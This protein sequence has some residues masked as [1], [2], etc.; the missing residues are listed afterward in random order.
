[1]NYHILKTNK[2]Q[3]QLVM[4]I[5]VPA[6]NNLAAKTFSECILEDNELNKVSVLSDIT[7]P[8]STALAAGTLIEVT[9]NV[10]I[11]PDLSNAAKQA[12]LDA[13]YT[14]AVTRTQNQL[15][16]RYWAW[17]YERDVV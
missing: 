6:G 17:G 9:E 12:V 7:A 2:K 15:Q 10:K 4:H 14:N 8:E 5:D 3:I 16:K 13:H 11:N 1:M